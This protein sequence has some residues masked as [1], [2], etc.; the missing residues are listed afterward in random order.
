MN[1][2]KANEL[3]KGQET[4]RILKS[5]KYSVTFGS[6]QTI[7][8]GLVRPDTKK[9]LEELGYKVVLDPIGF[10]ASGWETDST[11]ISWK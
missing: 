7:W 3:S 11:I 4:K 1:A 6:T 9:E 5:I 10:F 2:K 8:S